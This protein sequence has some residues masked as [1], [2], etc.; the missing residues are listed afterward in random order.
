MRLSH[1]YLAIALSWLA[2]WCPSLWAQLPASAVNVAEGGTAAFHVPEAQGTTYQWQHDGVAIAGA[3]DATLFIAKVSSANQGT[4]SCT[5]TSASGTTTTVVGSLSIGTGNP[6]YL[7]GLSSR[8]FVGSTANDNLIVGFFAAGQPK[9]Y[10]IRGVGPTL[11]S[12]G[13]TDPLDAPFLTLFSTTSGV[14]AAN[15]GWQGDARLQ[16]AFNAT[17]DFPLP[18][19]SAD[20]AMLESLGDIRGG[21]A[22]YTAQVSTSSGSP[23][24]AI[25]EIYDDAPSLA[26][27]Q[28]LIAVS[29]RALV[30]SG[31]GILI[32]GFVVTG[33]NAMTVLIRAVGPTLAKY[34]VTGV[35]QQPVLTLFQINGSQPATEIGSNSGWNGDATLA[36]VF[37]LVGEFDLPSDSA[38]AALLITLPPGLYTA[39]VSGAN[40]TSG[41]A[42]AEVYEVSSGTT[43]KPTSD[44]TTPTITWATPSNVTL[45]TALSATQ[46]NAT[47]S[48]GGVNVP[49]TFSY[50][51]DAGTVMNTMG[52]QMLSV[53]FTPTDATH[54]NPAYATVS[55]TVVRGTPSY[56]FRN[57]KI[58]AG[59]Y[60][61]G[62]YF[63]PTEPNLMYA[64]TD[65]G[66]I[67]RWGP[68]DSHWVPLLDWLT[69]GFFNG[70]DAIGLDPTNPN[71]LYVAVGL[72]SN[73]WA[74]NGEMLIS[75]DQGAT[76]KTVPLNFKNGSNNPGRGM[77]ERIAV[78]PNM[79]SIVYFGTRQDGLRVSTDSGNTWPQATGLK[80]VTSVSIG[81]G[82]YMPM[83]VVSVLPIKA[84]GSSGA[85]TPV[86]YAAVAGTGLNG[87][88]QALYVTTNG[89]S[90]TSTWTAVAGQ[91]SFASAPKPMSPMQAKLGPNGS[92]YILYGDG[93]GSDGDTVGQL[94]K[95]TPDSSWTSGT[96]TQIVLPVNVGGP[97]DQQGFG[98]V[99][100][101]PSHPGTIMV[102]TLNQ[103][104]PT[105]DVVYRSTDDGVTW[106]DVSS[107]KAPGNSSSM[108]PNL[109]THDN[110]NAPYVGAP[111]TVSTGNWITGLAIDPFNP[112][113]AMYSFGGGL[114]ITHDLTK[115]DPSASSLGIVD[116]KFEDEGI[117][118]TA[119]NVLLAPPSGSTILLSGIG[120][121]Y[122]FA[123]TDL[124]VSPAQGNYKVSQAMPT[125][126]DFQQNMP[127]T[128]LRASDGTYGATPLGVISTDGGF[129]WAGFATMPTGTT[130]GGGSIA[131]AADGS[132][133]VWATQDTSSVWYSKDGGKT[134]TASTGIQ[135]QSQIVADR[136]KAGVFYG[137]SG[138][139]G[140]LTMSTDGGVTFSTIQTG[141]PIAV[142]FT[143]APTLYSLPDAQGHLW[144]TAGGNADGLYTN[145]GSAA[146]PQLTQIAG[147]QKSTSLGYG[148]AAP[149]S[150]QLTLFI[151]GTIGT[152]WGLFRST[153]GGAS[154][155]RIN[156]DAHQYGG[157]DH[158]TGDMRTFGTV[159][160]SGSGRG[161]L[162]GTSA[163]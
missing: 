40:G 80:V 150:S 27:G 41:V 102:G 42:L 109:A 163:N 130:T 113:H 32:D 122:G 107:V 68:K 28:R 138:R 20:T 89:G 38:D 95:F 22:G 4:Y 43:T 121:V 154:W 136:A 31:D 119:V 51:P 47:A 81:G 133:I 46:L 155:I 112:D 15:G 97:P 87:N 37:R 117:E 55:A 103:Y 142:P 128:V 101:D 25:A 78:D 99:A 120:D 152:Q 76:F 52:P 111:G 91:P 94:W 160:F 57:V 48:Y 132:S 125:S 135:A 70:G 65:I 35:L 23:G 18:A 96:W 77:G 118:E 153:D 36:S 14:L 106:R 2:L 50:T 127:T 33:H 61:P 116:W 141:L 156:D 17:G 126:M 75:N 49:G 144:L 1:A 105:G 104:W 26:P 54:F 162:W 93:A 158:V 88:S 62:V 157:I 86:V 56:S 45:G 145:T 115:A 29:S 159:Y 58:L 98:S 34:G 79:P 161:I 53:T 5:A 134:W 83:G 149:G 24:V 85:A 72:Y 84:S 92:L 63:H 74:G 131:I 30:K 7:V 59:G 137:Y 12:F 110:T 39:Q 19:T 140:T 44:K 146:S 123:H 71:K 67:Y 100:V 10:L 16:A 64:R 3:T 108:S 69:D 129:T 148:K 114:W 147:V 6:G 66:G 13:I 60:I 90:T 73:S 11:A 82:Q 143:P 124:T 9:P 8:A 21:S 151:A 139:T